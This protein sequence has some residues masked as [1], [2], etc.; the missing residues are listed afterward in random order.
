MTSPFPGPLSRY[1]MA[2]GALLAA[3]LM[4]GCGDSDAPS[5]A[6][7]LC[8]EFLGRTIEGAAVTKATLVAAEGPTPEQCVVR[9]EMPQDLDFE[10]RLPTGWNKRTLFL[11]GGGFDGSVDGES[12][13]HSPDLWTAIML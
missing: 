7:S 12:A 3:S 9:A 6:A 5:S 13:S 1:A 4:S 11:G 10:V 8:K 2:S